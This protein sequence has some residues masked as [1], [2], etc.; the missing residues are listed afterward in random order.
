MAA[1]TLALAVVIADASPAPAAAPAGRPGVTAG[2]PP[3]PDQPR[4]E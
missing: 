2:Q 3:A 4:Q 1:Q